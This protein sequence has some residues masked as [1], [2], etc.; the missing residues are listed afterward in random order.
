[1]MLELGVEPAGAGNSRE[2]PTR[3]KQIELA[4]GSTPNPDPI[5]PNN[6]NHGHS[7][8]LGLSLRLSRT[9]NTWR[10]RDAAVMI[11]LRIS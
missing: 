5:N 11:I 8:G 10:I 4:V 7:L 2:E 9:R 1:M 6:H 3:S